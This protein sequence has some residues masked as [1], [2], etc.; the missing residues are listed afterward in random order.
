SSLRLSMESWSRLLDR[1]H[2]MHGRPLS[3]D[4]FLILSM[5]PSVALEALVVG[6]FSL[7]LSCIWGRTFLFLTLLAGA[8]NICQRYKTFPISTSRQIGCARWCPRVPL[9]STG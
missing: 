4:G 1:H 5:L 8:A 9:A 2:L 6:G 7:N 3:S